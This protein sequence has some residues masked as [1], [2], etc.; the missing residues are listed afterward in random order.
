[1]ITVVLF[2]STQLLILCFKGY[3]SRQA[4]GKLLLLADVGEMGELSVIRPIMC[5][6]VVSCQCRREGVVLGIQQRTGPAS[7]HHTIYNDV[8]VR[9]SWNNKNLTTVVI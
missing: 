3:V 5:V 2:G 8:L 7:T 4:H 9:W 1:M 6:S